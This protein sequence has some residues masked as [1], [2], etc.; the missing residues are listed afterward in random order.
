MSGP[1]ENPPLNPACMVEVHPKSAAIETGTKVF[2]AFFRYARKAGPDFPEYEITWLTENRMILQFDKQC[3]RR[4]EFTRLM[5]ASYEKC[6]PGE[7]EMIIDDHP[8][9]AI[10]TLNS[11]PK[12]IFV[13]G[14]PK[15]TR[16]QCLVAL[17]L[18]YFYD[19]DYYIMKRAIEIL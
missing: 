9:G 3:S 10:K 15:F 16:E 19:F 7:A 14:R 13:P 18:D 11:M 12:I 2:F 4:L 17:E 1:R 6:Y 5:A 8:V